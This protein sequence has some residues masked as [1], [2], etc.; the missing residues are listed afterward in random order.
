MQVSFHLN[1]NCNLSCQNC[2]WFSEDVLGHTEISHEVYIDWIL[3]HR[4][5]KIRLT[6]G[7]P[8]LYSEITDLIK[9]IP[10]EME[11]ELF[12][13]GT[14]LK[15]K[16]IPDQKN[17][18]L[19]VGVNREVEK[20]FFC[21]IKKHYKKVKFLSFQNSPNCI[22]LKDQMMEASQYVSFIDQQI[23]C[24]PKMVRFGTDGHAYCCEIGLRQKTKELRLPFSIYSGLPVL[25]STHHCQVKP[26][27]LSNFTYEQIIR[28][29]IR[30]I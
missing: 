2:H 26:N 29:V 13:N 5:H 8:L 18:C 16:K 7:E 24:L 4:P 14:L 27:C 28:R 23:D 3:L 25:P 9:K 30:K 10:L 22:Q 15:D 11:I 17:L 20:D 21:K 12:T 19:C 1:D 6:G